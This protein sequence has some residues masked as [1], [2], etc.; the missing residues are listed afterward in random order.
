M[1]DR[2]DIF[3]DFATLFSCSYLVDI[4]AFRS[5]NHKRHSEHSVGSR[6]EN[7]KH[8]VA[9]SYG[10]KHL[11]SLGTSDPVTL[12]LLKR[13]S[14]VYLFKS[15]EQ[16]LRISRYSKT[17]LIHHLLFHRISTADRHSFTYLIIGKDCSELGTPVD[18]SVA[19]IGYTIVHKYVALFFFAHRFPLCRGELNILACG[20]I[21]A[22]AALLFKI[23]LKIF[24]RH[25]LIE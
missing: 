14:P 15:F 8:F 10:E 12:G 25:G 5:E 1:F 13:I 23:G 22:D 2:L 18:H 9:V 20:R 19:K 24:Y 16:T 6:S 21:T 11:G 17:P 3:V 7:F 4:D